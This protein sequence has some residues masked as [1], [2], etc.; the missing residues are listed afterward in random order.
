MSGKDRSHRAAAIADDEGSVDRLLCAAAEGRPEA[1]RKLLP[2]VYD[3]LRALARA[4]MASERP[5]HTLQATALVHEAYLRLVGGRDP[6]WANRAH[7]FKA[8]ADA[9]RRILIDHARARGGPARG[10]GRHRVPLDVLDLAAADE[11]EEILALDEAIS[12]L[13]ADDPAAA[14]VVRLRFYAGMSV[15]DVAAATGR[16]PRSVKRDWAFA[17]ARLLRDLRR[18]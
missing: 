4:R 15:D 11:P 14:E 3:E 13:D 16:S 2:L 10:G 1:S 18:T 12:R 17:R 5:G 7:F 9:M 8:A 6:G